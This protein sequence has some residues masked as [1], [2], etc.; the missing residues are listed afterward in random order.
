MNGQIQ[1]KTMNVVGL[2]KLFIKIQI[3]CYQPSYLLSYQAL[4]LQND[5]S[6]QE[7]TILI[8]E[9]YSISYEFQ[10]IDWSYSDY[11]VPGSCCRTVIGQLWYPCTEY[12]YCGLHEDHRFRRHM[13][14]DIS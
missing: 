8:N 13:L 3:K 5:R 4:M 10:I 1:L 6:Q 11:E 9:K 2:Y 7:N 14:V 12:A